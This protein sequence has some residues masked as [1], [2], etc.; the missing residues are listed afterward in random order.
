LLVGADKQGLAYVV[1]RDNLGHFNP[2]ND[3]QI[4]QEVSI[5]GTMFGMPAF[6]NNR[7]Y[8]Q[9]AGTTLKAFSISNGQINPTPLSQSSETDSSSRGANPSISANGQTNGVMWQVE[10]ALTP[11]ISTL[12]AYN[13][14]NLAQKLYDSY[15]SMPANSPEQLGFVKFV[16]PTI[17]NGK[18]YVGTTTSLGVFGL[19]SPTLSITRNPGSVQLTFK[20]PPDVTNIVQFS[21]NLATW[22]DLGPGTP[23]GGGVFQYTDST[24]IRASRFYRLR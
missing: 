13:A 20:S 1:D 15:T 17:A 18:V 8:F 5:G 23:V 2:V 16:T 24:T 19:Q 21:T 4:V 11:G 6:F 22:T 10:A 7:L 9:T 3:S 12:R 14:E